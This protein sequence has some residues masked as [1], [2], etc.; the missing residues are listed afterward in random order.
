MM[1][2]EEKKVFSVRYFTLHI[3]LCFCISILFKSIPPYDVQVP[4]I[5][6]FKV[7]VLIRMANSKEYGFIYHT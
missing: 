4:A 1:N 2:N 6:A 5:K 3:P 7:N